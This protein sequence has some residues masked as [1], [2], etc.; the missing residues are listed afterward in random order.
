M[1]EQG[2]GLD[3]Y[4]NRNENV[5]DWGTPNLEKQKNK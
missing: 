4:S 3:N 5:I 2:R 1:Q